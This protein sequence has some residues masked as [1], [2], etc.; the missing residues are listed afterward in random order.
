MNIVALIAALYGAFL[1]YSGNSAGL[2]PMEAVKGLGLITVGL[3]YLATNLPDLLA[4]LKGINLSS[5]LPKKV[6]KEPDMA[7]VQVDKTATETNIYAPKAFEFKD[8]ECLV[9]LRNRCAQA[10]SVE[11]LEACEKLNAVIFKLNNPM[12]N[13]IQKAKI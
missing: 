12:Q 6:N 10:G 4:R 9:H 13:E 11:G 1:L 7:D 8:L 2:T 3:A 5:L